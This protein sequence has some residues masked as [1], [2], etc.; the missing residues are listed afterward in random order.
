M[1]RILVYMKSMSDKIKKRKN[2]KKETVGYKAVSK[3]VG[4]DTLTTRK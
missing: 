4:S 1:N 3:H 2:L